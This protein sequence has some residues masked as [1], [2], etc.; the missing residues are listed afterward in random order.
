MSARAWLSFQQRD[1]SCIAGLRP[2]GSGGQGH[3]RPEGDQEN[4]RQGRD[5]D[6]LAARFDASERG[7]DEHGVEPSALQ[8]ERGDG[9]LPS[10]ED[11]D[12]GRAGA[13]QRGYAQGEE[14][15]DRQHEPDPG[16]VLDEE[17]GAGRLPGSGEGDGRRRRNRAREDDERQQEREPTRD[18]SGKEREARAAGDDELPKDARPEVAGPGVHADQDRGYG[19][20]L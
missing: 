4:R 8:Q 12:R 10:E 11:A 3:D 17:A 5:R 15:A 1:G 6:A 18:A 7:R 2:P 14:K 16:R 19:P 13:E 9:E 20:D